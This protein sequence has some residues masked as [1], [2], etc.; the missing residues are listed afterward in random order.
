MARGVQLIQLVSRLRA[1]IR[2]SS[3]VAIG[4][5]FED[6]LKQVLRRTQE[7]L[8][9]E[10]DWPYLQF[11]ASKTLSAGQRYY[12]MPSGMSD[13][14]ITDAAVSYNNEPLPV[15]TGI[16]FAEYAAYDSEQDE[17]ADPVERW[18][19][20]RTSASTTQIEVWPM[21]AS[22]QTLW[23]RGL[24]DLPALTSNDDTAVLDDNLIVLFAAAEILAGREAE[25]AKLKLQKA[26][27][28]LNALQGQM[29]GTSTPI[30]MGGSGMTVPRRRRTTI[31]I[32]S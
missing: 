9:N 22:A 23:F 15:E 13:L 32:S 12:D 11:Y 1:E 19:W 10:H 18:D 16:G 8:W 6:N 4:T 24:R 17:R 5:D 3:S 31:R 21:P 25:D 20:R 30:T 26:Q 29:V 2:D 7:E 14:R 27:K 28:L